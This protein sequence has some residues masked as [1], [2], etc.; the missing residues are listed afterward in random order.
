[1]EYYVEPRTAKQVA[2]PALQRLTTLDPEI[3]ATATGSEIVIHEGTAAIVRIAQPADRDPYGWG[4][5]TSAA[6]NGAK[7]GSPAIG[8]L[9]DQRI[10]Q[11]VFAGLTSSLDRFSRYADPQ[12]AREE[13]AA[14]DGV[15]GI[16]VTL[17]DSQPQMR[18]ARVLPG[19]PAARAG[20]ARGDLLVEIDGASTS[21]L[22]KSAALQRL[23]GPAGTRVALALKRSGAASLLHRTVFREF[24]AVP[25]VIGRRDGNIAIFRVGSFNQHTTDSLQDE[26][27]RLRQQMGSAQRGIILDLRG[28][29]GGLLDQAVSVADLFMED[30]QIAAT[31]GRNSAASEVFDASPGDIAA[32][33]PIVVL[34]DGGSASAA[35]I[36]AAALQDSGRA[37][38][39]GSPSFGKGTVQT[40]LR[41]PNDG[42]LTL[43]SARLYAPSGYL[44]HEHGVVPDLCTAGL[45]ERFDG[46]DSLL[47]HRISTLF[48]G[49]PRR[50]ALDEAGWR[51]LRSVC[52][53]Y[54]GGDST[55]TA[56]A[57]RVLADP[58]LYAA[59][60]QDDRS[61]IAARPVPPKNFR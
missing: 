26:F 35:E 10:E 14:R 52:P 22:G 37:V 17:D 55:E 3:K 41:L 45:P 49:V 60:M 34:A 21:T 33:L 11:V 8:A 53:S 36:V 23:R 9:S 58:A 48:G 59:L 40:Q 12:Q 29:P 38:V 30:G 13:Y 18:I 50:Q 31:R 15:D 61:T 57:E 44:L 2:L 47:Q 24:L 28:N 54:S 5:A 32:G 51:R 6:L 42:E 7:A 27:A 46:V 1:M 4:A 56:A 25:T 39:I 20:I 43:T 16:G 19:S